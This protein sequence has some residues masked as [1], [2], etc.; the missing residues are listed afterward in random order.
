MSNFFFLDTYAIFE[1]IFGNKSYEKFKDKLLVTSIFNLAELNYNLKKDF[2][3]G[4]SDR[5]TKEY[6]EI[7]EDI[8]IDDLIL[9][10]DLRTKNR[11]LS[12]PDCIGYVV[13]KRIGAKFLTGDK[14]FE[15]MSNVEFV[16]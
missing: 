9:A 7:L 15:K 5:L 16:K 3:K 2:S 13:A 1:I 4:V 8:E 10:S 12:L 11:K 14:E 6:S